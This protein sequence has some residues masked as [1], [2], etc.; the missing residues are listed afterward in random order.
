[1]SIRRDKCS[2]QNICRLWQNSKVTTYISK[3]QNSP[4]LTRLIPYVNLRNFL[5]MN[6][7]VTEYRTKI[8]TYSKEAYFVTYQVV[9]LQITFKALVSLQVNLL[10][11]Y[12]NLLYIYKKFQKTVDIVYCKCIVIYHSIKKK[13]VVMQILLS[14]HF[15]FF[16]SKVFSLIFHSFIDIFCC[17]YHNHMLIETLWSK[18]QKKKGWACGQNAYILFIWYCW[19]SF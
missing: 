14:I 5:N 10:T 4:F 12:T 7:G 15:F 16:F 13:W 2:S 9:Y 1:M 8:S 17:I 18:R 11:F 6:V 3:P 19:K